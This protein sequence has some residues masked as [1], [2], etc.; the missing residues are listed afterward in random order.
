M[1]S[2][3]SKEKG[4]KDGSRSKMHPAWRLLRVI[5]FIVAIYPIS[6]FWWSF[7]G[8][9]FGLVFFFLS[10]DPAWKRNGLV[11]AFTTGYTTFLVETLNVYWMALGL[12]ILFVYGIMLGLVPVGSWV[13]KKTRKKRLHLRRRVIKG[14]KELSSEA[15]RGIKIVVVVLP[16]LLWMFSSLNFSLMLINEPHLLW[17]HAP[18]TVNPGEN[19]PITVESWDIYE[20]LSCNY[21]GRV[22]FSLISYNLTDFSFIGSPNVSLPGAYA[23][24]GQ[25]FGQGFIPGYLIFDGRDN[26]KHV[27]SVQINT[28]GIH[29]ILVNDSLSGN[30]YWSNPI[31]VDNFSTSPK[32]YWGDLHGH[33]ILSDGSGTVEESY[34]YARHV[35]C[36]DYCAITDHGE[37]LS[38]HGLNYFGFTMMEAITNLAN[39]PGQFVALQGAE[40]T[41]HYVST[42]F[43]DFGHFTCVF[44]GDE[45]PWF[46]ANK[47][48]SPGA[49]WSF[50]DQYTAQSGERALAIPH[51]TIRS[52]FI[53]DWTYVNPKYVKLAEVTSVHGECLFEGHETLNYRGSVDVPEQITHGSSINDALKMGFNLTLSASGDN[54]D[55]HPGH[56]LSHT[57]AY[58][59]HNWPFS[60]AHARNGHPYPSGLTAVY[61][62]NLTRNGVFTGLENQRVYA[63]SDYARP[64][65][66]FTI[67][68]VSAG[69]GSTL[70]VPTNTTQRN[71]SIILAQDGAPAPGRRTAASVSDNWVPNWVATIEVIKN[72]LLWNQTVVTTPVYNLSLPDPEMING[73]SYDWSITSGGNNY[74]NRFSDNPV[75]PST[76]NTGGRDYYIVRIVGANYRTAYAGPIWVES[77]S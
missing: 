66:N 17:V 37:Q 4:T 21:H 3:S 62:D 42:V 55:G 51:H 32:I 72:G 26:G 64:F 15:K 34:Y 59:G 35:A 41:P 45:L 2:D 8:I 23:F 12:L 48:T 67:D 30:T 9:I 63:S 40:W 44:S 69:D 5:V 14:I 28:T 7:I 47:E 36:L 71:I 61:A 53:Q 77:L 11:L 56:S 22:E 6:L 65:L 46:T 39:A 49:L 10:K 73:T 25:L 57:P 33:T 50:F 60:T 38:L 27:F 1:K 19:F 24:T 68:G 76:L 58:I 70:L 18:S 43:I 20:R 13:L 75:D 16:I 52:T 74:I 29:Y 54:H 31:M